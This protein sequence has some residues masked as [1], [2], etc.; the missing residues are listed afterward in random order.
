MNLM[1]GLRQKCEVL[2][3]N[4]RL[5]MQRAIRLNGV[6]A[7]S[8]NLPFTLSVPTAEDYPTLVFGENGVGFASGSSNDIGWSEHKHY[9]NKCAY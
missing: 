9:G 8:Y 7:G 2:L 3:R 5:K 6:G 1:I 4:F